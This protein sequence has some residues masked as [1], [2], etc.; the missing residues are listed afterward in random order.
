[1]AKVAIIMGSESDRAVVEEAIPF[2]EYFGIKFEIKMTIP[3]S[4]VNGRCQDSLSIYDRGFQF[5]D[6]L[7]ETL[8]IVDGKPCYWPRHLQR[9]QKGCDRLK[10]SFT[11]FEL[12]GQ[13]VVEACS[14]QT[15]AVLK[16]VITRGHSTRGYA[17][18]DEIQP[19]RVLL[20]SQMPNYPDEYYGKGVELVICKT[21]LSINPN[22]A[23]IKH[24]NRLEQV[25]ARSEWQDDNIAE[26][27]MCDTNGNII[28]GTMSNVFMLKDNKL[29]T[30]YLS[31]CGVE[32]IT[33]GRIIEIAEML[34]YDVDIASI[35][36]NDLMQADEVFVCN[37]LIGIWP[38]KKIQ[39]KTWAP[40]YVSHALMQNLNA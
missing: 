39:D 14:G 34:G 20:V 28:E 35:K 11:D 23:G 25:L 38:A 33:R 10:I 37:S 22:L 6:G 17:V 13:E 9:L 12:L 32:G 15:S 8:R 30:P 29:I 26:G 5:G 4:F 3:K 2:L 1:M 21:P 19:T 40:G 36:Y 18:A 24:L 16:I 27:L 7:F 31:Q